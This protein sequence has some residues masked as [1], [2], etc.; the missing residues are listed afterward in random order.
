MQQVF[1]SSYLSWTR[2]VQDFDHHCKWIN[3]CVSRKNYKYKSTIFYNTR[4]FIMLLIFVAIE[5]STFFVWTTLFIID[6]Y[7]RGLSIIDMDHYF[8]DAKDPRVIAMIVWDVLSVVLFSLDLKLLSFHI[9]LIRHKIT[10]YDYI[11]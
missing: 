8:P 4:S 7:T 6:H 9:Y 11:I 5:T 1:F 2:C 3:N 10:T